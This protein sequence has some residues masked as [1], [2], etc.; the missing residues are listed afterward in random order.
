MLCHSRGFA[1]LVARKQCF[2]VQA[3]FIVRREGAAPSKHSSLAPA[4][5]NT[6][7]PGP[8]CCRPVHPTLVPVALLGAL[9]E[10]QQ[11]LQSLV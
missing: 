6:L 8:V 1:W 5:E 10:A 4:G 7:H 11:C 9:R 2:R 3:V